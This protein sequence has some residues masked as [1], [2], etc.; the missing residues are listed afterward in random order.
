[1][2]APAKIT[3]TSASGD[4]EEFHHR[5]AAALAGVKQQAGRL[6]P[7]YIDGQ[8]V[9]TRSEPLVDRSPV[10]T[11]LVLGLRP[12]PTSMPPWRPPSELSGGGLDVPGRI[13]CRC[14]AGPPF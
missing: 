11:S 12:Q 6:H 10:D 14:S 4:L 2:S 9:E 5:F 7:F 3:Y 13:G 8:P 1:M